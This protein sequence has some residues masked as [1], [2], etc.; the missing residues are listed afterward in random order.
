MIIIKNKVKL[1]NVIFYLTAFLSGLFYFIKLSDSNKNSIKNLIINNPITFNNNIYHIL[2]IIIIIIL[3]F[4]IIGVIFN[5]FYL[6]LEYFFVGFSFAAFFY[7]Y[8]FNG[9]VYGLLLNLFIKGIYLLLLSLLIH[10][11]FKISANNYY[12]LFKHKFLNNYFKPFY[13]IIIISLLIIINDIF[14]KVFIFDVAS[15]FKFIL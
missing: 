8:H 4:F 10:K 3:S 13:Q 5:Y 15:L 11:C 1:V 7:V 14:I 2:I 9:L 6:F 12:Y